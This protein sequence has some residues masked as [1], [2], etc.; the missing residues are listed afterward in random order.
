[1]EKPVAEET[2]NATFSQIRGFAERK[3]K[4]LLI[5]ED[6]EVE[7]MAIQELIGGGDVT[8]TVVATGKKALEAIRSNSFECVVL[9]L[10]LPDMS[11]FE[12]IEK[13]KQEPGYAEVPFIVYTGRDLTPREATELERIAETVIIKGVTSPDRL[14]AETAL[15]LHRIETD[16]P[17]PKRRMLRKVC[18]ADPVLD[19]RK[20][21]IVDDDIRNIFALTS[22]LERYHMKVV[23]AESGKAALD[24]LKQTPDV[25]VILIDVMMPE[26]DGYETT[27]EIRRADRCGS[28]PIIAVTAKAM[29]GDREKCIAAGMS[30]Y[31][32]KPVDIGQLLSLL[33]VWLYK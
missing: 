20:V 30:D 17:E 24:L 33:R 14:L 3:T 19:S 26:M 10:G 6:N 8:S 18:D 28:L 2:L 4:N 32:P 29:K 21:L 1:M 12:L 9:D 25:D 13:I 23:Y 7:G 31:I 5:V 15:F 16:L 22:C 27:R 11:G